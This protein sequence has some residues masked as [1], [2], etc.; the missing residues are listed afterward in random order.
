MITI[1]TDVLEAVRLV[2]GYDTVAALAR[3]MGLDRTTV[4]RTLAGKL[5]IST[6]FLAGMRLAFP[7]LTT[8]H[9]FDFH[10]E[11]LSA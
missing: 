10:A 9:L 7:A 1:R 11:Q 2:A 3:A 5:P 6:D 4:S 8:D